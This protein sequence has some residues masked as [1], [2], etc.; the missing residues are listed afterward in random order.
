[1]LCM[2]TL[3]VNFRGSLLLDVRRMLPPERSPCKMLRLCKYAKALAISLCG[4]PASHDPPWLNHPP[5]AG[6]HCCACPAGESMGP[7]TTGH[8][9]KGF[10][11]GVLSQLHAHLA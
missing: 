3:Q 8:D 6:K 2:P 9:L 10:S 7:V 4:L 5:T 11:N 1:M